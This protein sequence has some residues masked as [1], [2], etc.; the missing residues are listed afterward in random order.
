MHSESCLQGCFCRALDLTELV[1]LAKAGGT[2][3]GAI[4]RPVFELSPIGKLPTVVGLLFMQKLLICG[5]KTPRIS[6]R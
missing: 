1:E 5:R 2:V 3:I 4:S 6:A